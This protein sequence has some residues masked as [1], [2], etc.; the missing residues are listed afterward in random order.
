MCC[1]VHFQHWYAY[2]GL[3]ALF[4]VDSQIKGHLQLSEWALTCIICN[5]GRQNP[6]PSAVSLQY[7]CS[8]SAVSTSSFEVQWSMFWS[9]A[10]CILRC[11]GIALQTDMGIYKKGQYRQECLWQDWYIFTSF[12]S[13]NLPVTIEHTV[14]MSSA[15]KPGWPT[16]CGT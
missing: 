2:W 14:G 7:I 15:W 10:K 1:H 12:S 16:F 11:A 13:V 3:P 5:S 8:V 6:C 9:A 4:T